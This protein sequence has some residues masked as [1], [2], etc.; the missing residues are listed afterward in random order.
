MILDAQDS[1][2]RRRPYQS[3]ALKFN[4][5]PCC[6]LAILLLASGLRAD[7]L[8]PNPSFDKGVEPAGWRLTG[9]KGQWVAASD[10]GRGA[11]MVEGNGDDEGRWETERIHLRPGT[12]LGLRFS[13]RRD[14]AG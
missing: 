2:M 5:R 11:L 13:A 3:C 7:N 14:P 9:G 10:Q 12:L 4:F 8:L 1:T 6:V